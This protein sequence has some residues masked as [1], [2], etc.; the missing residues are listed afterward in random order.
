MARKST[1]G[2][3]G[4]VAG[5]TLSNPNA[6]ALQRSL[7]A[8]AL[9]QAG[10]SKATGK[11]MEAKASTALQNPNASARMKQLAWS[12]TSQSIRKR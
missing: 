9:A 8:S 2:T 7:A 5:R 12:V 11:A 3:V 6:S 1:S 10:T 4:T